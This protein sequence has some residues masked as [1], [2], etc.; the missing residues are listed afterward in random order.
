MSH[1]TQ[2]ALRATVAAAGMA[3]LGMALVTTAAPLMT[4]EMPRVTTAAYST[5][6]H[7]P[8]HGLS[9]SQN[10]PGHNTFQHPCQA[11][12]NSVGKGNVQIA[13]VPLNRGARPFAHHS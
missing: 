3:T 11:K 8:C 6:W 1:Y 7:D 5:P 9:G 4:S 12:H 13:G 10:L 2:R